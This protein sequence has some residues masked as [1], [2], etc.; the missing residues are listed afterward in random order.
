MNTFLED[1]VCLLLRD[2]LDLLEVP[3]WCV[4]HRLDRVVASIYYEL[5]V[6]LGE[7]AETLFTEVSLGTGSMAHEVAVKTRLKSCQRCGRPR[8]GHALIARLCLIILL[9]CLGHFCGDVCGRDCK[10]RD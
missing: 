10:V 8:A 9:L 6:A 1:F 4:S 7:T 5:N 3:P 2:A